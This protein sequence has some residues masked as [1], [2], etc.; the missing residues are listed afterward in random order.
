MLHRIISIGVI[1]TFSAKFTVNREAKAIFSYLPFSEF[2]YSNEMR[3]ILFVLNNITSLIHGY[4]MTNIILF[5]FRE[6]ASIKQKLLFSTCIFIIYN[7]V[8]IYGAYAING[9]Q[10]L[11]DFVYLAVTIPNPILS[12]ICY[13]SCIKILKLSKY[14]AIHINTMFYLYSLI[15]KAITRAICIYLFEQPNGAEKYNYLLDALSVVT[16]VIIVAICYLIV[17]MLLRKSNI[18]IKLSECLFVNSIPRMLLY[19]F[20]LN[21]VA[22]A[23][24]LIVP[25]IFN[26][27]PFSFILVAI[28]LLLSLIVNF[29]HISARGRKAEIE[30]KN[31]HIDVLI[32]SFEQFRELKHDFYNILQTYSGYIYVGDLE[33]LKKYHEELLH[34]TVAAG[35]QIE[36]NKRI[37]ENPALISLLCEKQRHALSLSVHIRVLISSSISNINIDTMSLCRALGNF[38]DNAIEAASESKERMV[39]FS[40]EKKENNNTL[41]MIVNSTNGTVD[42][43][44]I[45]IPGTSSKPG[46]SGL[47]ISSARKI[48]SRFGNCIVQ[49]ESYNQRFTV[50]IELS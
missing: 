13:T 5:I 25:L 6:K 22:Y 48:L 38:L 3:I 2:A 20:G 21:C 19:Q 4:I 31:A 9:F 11:N 46:H 47:G 41:I 17:I 45:V 14:R 10:S 27:N 26:N 32:D 8:I 12:L 44:S 15:L 7:T 33:K 36:F 42:T 29:Y 30:N 28:I 37:Q 43:S 16:G 35:D 18:M 24:L 40:I 23:V 50:Y 49:F 1:A 39:T 34:T